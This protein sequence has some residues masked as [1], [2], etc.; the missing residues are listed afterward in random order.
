MPVW[1][2]LVVI[3]GVIIL[4][5]NIMKKI[6]PKNRIYPAWAIFVGVVFTVFLILYVQ[7][8]LIH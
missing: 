6:E 5:I 7:I 3:W 8:Q 2:A 1:I 4:A